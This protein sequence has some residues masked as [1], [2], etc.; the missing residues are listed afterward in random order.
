MGITPQSNA[1][2][3]DAPADFHVTLGV[4]VAAGIKVAKH[5]VL[6]DLLGPASGRELTNVPVMNGPSAA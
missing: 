3:R 2:L 1:T 4:V 6:N 5:T